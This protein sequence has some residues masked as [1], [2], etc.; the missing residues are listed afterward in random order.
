MKQTFW[1]VNSSTFAHIEVEDATKAVV[2]DNGELLFYN[3]KKEL[4]GAASP[5]YWVRYYRE[6]KEEEKS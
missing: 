4:V 2:A 3:N 1:Y 5:G 6:F